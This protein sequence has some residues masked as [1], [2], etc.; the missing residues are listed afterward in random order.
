[1]RQGEMRKVLWNLSQNLPEWHWP[2]VGAAAPVKYGYCFQRKLHKSSG[3]AATMT[4]VAQ[5][6]QRLS[7]QQIKYER[8]PHRAL[9]RGSPQPSAPFLP[10][11]LVEQIAARKHGNRRKLH[12]SSKR[13]VLLVAGPK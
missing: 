12:F 10:V 1:M 4:L 11:H 7:M 2:R 5:P 9:L 6:G 13:L 3:L 8:P